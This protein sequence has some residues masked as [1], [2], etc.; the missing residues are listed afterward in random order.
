MHLG[1]LWVSLWLA[2]YCSALLVVLAER[3]GR[4]RLEVLLR[5]ATLVEQQSA[6]DTQHAKAEAYA[7]HG[8]LHEGVNRTA[9]TLQPRRSSSQQSARTGDAQQTVDRREQRPLQARGRRS[10]VTTGRGNF[11]LEL[12][13]R[14][15][16]R[17]STHAA[18]GS[19][20]QPVSASSPIAYPAPTAPW[21][22]VPQLQPA[23]DDNVPLAPQGWMEA[24]AWQPILEPQYAAAAPSVGFSNRPDVYGDR[25][26][27]AGSPGINRNS[28]PAPAA[29][30]PLQW[31]ISRRGQSY[32]GAVVG[33]PPE[34]VA[35]LAAVP[36]PP[37]LQQRAAFEQLFGDPP[38]L[39]STTQQAASSTAVG[40]TA[41]AVEE[42]ADTTPAAVVAT[43]AGPVSETLAVTEAAAATEAATTAPPST[44]TAGVTPAVTTAAADVAATAAAAGAAEPPAASTA[45]PTG[46][47]AITSAAPAAG[48]EPAAVTTASP[49]GT[50]AVTTAA[51]ATTQPEAATASP[52]VAGAM[53]TAAPAAGTEPAV[54]STASPIATGAVTT[55][56]VATTQSA[57]AATAS[58]SVAGAMTTAAPAAGTEP[59][60]VSTASP[61][62]TAAVTTAAVAT[63]QP[64]AATASPSGDGAMTTAAPAAGT[65][66][67]VV[68][69]AS[70]VGTA[71]VTTAAVA[72]TQSAE[73]ATASPSVAGAMSTA[74]PAAGTEPAAVSTASPAETAAVTTAAV[75][76]EQPEAAT[77][78]PSGDGA[79]TT[80]VPAA[81]TEPAA[82]STARPVGTA[83]VTTAAVATE[84][85]EAG[86]AAATTVAASATEPPTANAP[87]EPVAATT[88]AVSGTAGPVASTAMPLAATAAVTTA[89]AAAP[90]QTT[91]EPAMATAAAVTT[92]AGPAVAA[93]TAAAAAST[94]APAAEPPPQQ[95]PPPAAQAQPPP[96]QPLPPPAQ[97][98]PPLQQPPP[99]AYYPEPAPSRNPYAAPEPVFRE[100][101][102][103]SL[104]EPPSEPV[105]LPP[106]PAAPLE[107]AKAKPRPVTAKPAKAAKPSK[108][109]KPTGAKVPTPSKKTSNKP[110]AKAS[111]AQKPAVKQATKRPSAKPTGSAK[112]AVKTTDAGKTAQKK[113]PPPAP[114]RP[115]AKPVS[116]P[117]EDSGHGGAPPGSGLEMAIGRTMGWMLLGFV[118]LGMGGVYTLAYPDPQ[119]QAYAIK[120]AFQMVAIFLA[121]LYVD[122]QS[123]LVEHIAGPDMMFVKNLVTLVLFIHWF[124]VISHIGVGGLAFLIG[125]DDDVHAAEGFVSHVCAFTMLHPMSMLQEECGRTIVDAGYMYPWVVGFY[126]LCPMVVLGA[127]CCLRLIGS[128]YRHTYGTDHHR[129][130]AASEGEAEACGILLGFLLCQ[131][132]ICIA[133]GDAPAEHGGKTSLPAIIVT[134]LLTYG[135]GYALITVSNYNKAFGSDDD[136]T[137]VIDTLQPTTAFLFSFLLQKLGE[138]VGGH[139]LPGGHAGAAVIHAAMFSPFIVV[140]IVAVDRLADTGSIDDRTGQAI[141]NSLALLI[142][143]QYEQAFHHSLHAVTHDGGLSEDLETLLS[144]V[145]HVLFVAALVPAWRK[146]LAP[147]AR[148]PVPPRLRVGDGDGADGEGGAVQGPRRW[149]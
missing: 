14:G 56:A 46:T 146:L 76:T 40:T 70:P 149:L 26:D 18:D 44:V 141:L 51:V 143:L 50:A 131:C 139:A 2:W 145:L 83:A 121:L 67:A 77:A 52:S 57:E 94:A 17:K 95:A 34:A 109:A 32:G 132:A 107:P 133:N 25:Q 127:F 3:P 114:P 137:E 119:V 96:P 99:P 64:E 1:G 59:A 106:K 4:Q 37:Q 142:A 115:P 72:T 47:G 11:L 128:R 98:P 93:T 118:I 23:P 7:V 88:L 68:S 10:F 35:R 36:L 22:V 45:S 92:A 9:P 117:K 48:T 80:A 33:Q 16:A 30:D 124:L 130:E 120:A 31:Q 84:Q 69:T 122:L 65:E 110:T 66:P 55:A 134:L 58:P 126:V 28:L 61:A 97:P 6:G 43:S 87:A 81:V 39:P 82:V 147:V 42:A 85:S 12:G 148:L 24:G 111:K 5:P 74:A 41:A 100:P 13:S 90:G 108:A 144:V 20:Q 29:A 138:Y 8:G 116:K 86:T 15:R 21:T 125:N 91:A 101:P 79:I 135:A 102:R 73:A 113:P 123:H 112:A 54:V 53:T 49:A 140:A 60:A 105:A 63:E 19:L 104:P 71:A 38:P 75:A 62:E 136:D 89:A 129:L 78:S 103:R 27:V